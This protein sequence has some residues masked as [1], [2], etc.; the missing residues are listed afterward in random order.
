MA[1]DVNANPAAHKSEL[2]AAS[3]L[4]VWRL[5]HFSPSG[6]TS[7]AQAATNYANL[8]PPQ[9]AGQFFATDDDSGGVNGF[10]FF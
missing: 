8:T 7:A 6:S 5:V 2:H 9:V 1:E 3:T 4:P 10:Y